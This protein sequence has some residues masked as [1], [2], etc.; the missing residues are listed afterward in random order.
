[1]YTAT[2]TRR[3]KAMDAQTAIITRTAAQTAL[4]AQQYATDEVLRTFLEQLDCKD[5]SR[6]LYARTLPLFFAWI[7]RTGRLLH[8]VTRADIIAYRDGLIDGT[9]TADG[10]KRSALTAA[11]YL[12]AVKLFYKWLESVGAYPNVTAGVKLPE[13]NQKFEREP[14]TAEQARELCSAV[15]RSG[16]LR[17]IAII[18]ILV[19]CGLRTI[20]VIRA[21]VSDIV[22]RGGILTLNVQGKGHVS[23]NNFVTLSAKCAADIQAYLATRHDI[24]GKEGAALQGVPLFTCDSNNNANGRLTTR[25]ISGIAKK[26]LCAVGLNSRAYTAHSLRHTFGCLALDLYNDDIHAVQLQMRHA[27]A[28]TTQFYIYHRDEQRRI[29]LA[30]AHS[31]DT[32][33]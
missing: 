32:L 2:T 19:R 6:S 21:D 24:A 8:A 12:T 3:Y 26:Y 13:R 23:K 4:A 1:M 16:N 20:E 25:T 17:D 33:I 22:L 28:A 5:S 30:K 27:S 7:S 14:L 11:A 31:I 10:T 18:N 15:E 29:K 9:A